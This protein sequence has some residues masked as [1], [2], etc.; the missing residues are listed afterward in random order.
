MDT[1]DR[2]KDRKLADEA[3]KRHLLD[4]HRPDY[5]K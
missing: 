2:I 3:M 5:Y 4:M 1:D